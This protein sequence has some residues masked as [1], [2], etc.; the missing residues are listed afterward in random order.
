MTTELDWKAGYVKMQVGFE[1]LSFYVLCDLAITKL[2]NVL[3]AWT[4]GSHSNFSHPAPRK[5]SQIY[6]NPYLCWYTIT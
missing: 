6:K 3:L 1:R 2:K 4:K 5:G